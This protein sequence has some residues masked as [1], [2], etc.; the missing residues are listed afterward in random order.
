MSV[1]TEQFTYAVADSG[2]L[3][4]LIA[5]GPDAALSA[6][7][8][9]NPEFK[10]VSMVVL[11]GFDTPDLAQLWSV[12]DRV[13][14]ILLYRCTLT[15]ETL[16][17]LGQLRALT[18]FVIREC[19]FMGETTDDFPVDLSGLHQLNLKSFSWLKTP[20]VPDVA[21][22]SRKPNLSVLQLEDAPW[23]TDAIID[24]IL[25]GHPEPLAL[26]LVRTSVTT[27]WRD[28]YQSAHPQA[29]I[30]FAV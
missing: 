19:R 4:R 5:G 10:D 20:G 15:G 24:E 18:G 7:F 6:E 27:G 22:L 11:N 30:E 17:A 28:R 1:G 12:A 21:F 29:N 13:G 26:K 23:C 9:D 25:A 3:L 14:A 16:A 8:F 2:T